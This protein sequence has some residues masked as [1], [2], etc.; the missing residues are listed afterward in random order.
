MKKY[1]AAILILSLLLGVATYFFV[2]LS[3]P[4]EICSTVTQWG[5]E[6][7][8]AARL[9]HPMG[10]AWRESILYVADTENGVVKKFRG[11]GSLVNEWKGLKRPVEHTHSFCRNDF[12]T[13]RNF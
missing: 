3:S 13:I 1:L 11:D 10:L 2:P 6:N 7:K 9:N 5:I 8:D 4:T 12:C